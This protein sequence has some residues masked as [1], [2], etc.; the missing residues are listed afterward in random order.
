MKK[1]IYYLVFISLFLF[2][3]CVHDES[4]NFE[5][6]VKRLDTI[7]ATDP[8]NTSY[9]DYADEFGYFWDVYSQNVIFL[10][11]RIICRFFE[12]FSARTR[13]CQA[14]SRCN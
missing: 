10:P 12:R 2:M 13:F 3:S 7:Y 8:F 11:C 6:E 5:L 9:N 1:N 4:A 14:L